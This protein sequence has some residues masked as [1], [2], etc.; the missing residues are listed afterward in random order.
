MWLLVILF[1]VMLLF[2]VMVEEIVLGLSKDEVSIIVIFDGFEILLFG[3]IKCDCL[4][5][6]VDMLGVIVVIVGFNELVVVCCKD[7][8][9]GIWVNIVLVCVDIV[10]LFYVIVI[11]GLMGDVLLL[12]EDLNYVILWQ[13][14]IVGEGG[15][16][17]FQMLDFIEVFMWIKVDEGLYQIFEN[18][19]D[20]EDSILFYIWINL[21]LNIIEGNYCI[22]IFLICDG[23][24]IDEF[25]MEIFVFKVGL[26]CW[27]YSMF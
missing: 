24:V 12:I 9:V 23:C 6:D 16:S 7:C 22:C 14:C 27:F 17:F 8:V 2:I 13:C 4:L 25:I 21:L 18:S 26:E 1:F 11:L 10:L 3:V 15:E 20:V 5:L 19:V